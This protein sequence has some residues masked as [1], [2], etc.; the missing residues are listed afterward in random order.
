[1]TTQITKSY[2]YPIDNYLNAFGDYD[3]LVVNYNRESGHCVPTYRLEGPSARADLAYPDFLR[4]CEVLF[5][6]IAESREQ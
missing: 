1:M 3:K 2:A 6:H 5:N 4:A